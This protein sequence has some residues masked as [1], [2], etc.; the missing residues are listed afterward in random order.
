MAY[1]DRIKKYLIKI[2]WGKV[3]RKILLSFILAY[4]LYQMIYS[5]YQVSFS[6]FLFLFVASLFW[7]TSLK[8]GWL[9]IKICSLF[10][11][12]ALTI[13]GNRRG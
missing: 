11:L 7:R 6:L 9:L 8:V 10:V 5:G 13:G 4:G 3:I 1:V 12:L 2:N